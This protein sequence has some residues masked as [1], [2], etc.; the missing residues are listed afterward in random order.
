MQQTMLS[1]IKD[2]FPSNLKKA[3]GET[4]LV[5]MK[6]LESTKPRGSK[7]KREEEEDVEMGE[8]ESEDDGRRSFCGQNHSHQSRSLPGG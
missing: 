5:A 2:R 7:R 3:S 6:R 8:A 1:F 4:A